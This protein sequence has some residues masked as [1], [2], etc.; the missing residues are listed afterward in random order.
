MQVHGGT[1]VES[2][3]IGWARDIASCIFRKGV[4]GAMG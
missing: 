2:T 3:T 4:G 1:E